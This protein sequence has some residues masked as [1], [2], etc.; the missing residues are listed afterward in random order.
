MHFSSEK[1]CDQIP[2]IVLPSWDSS[3]QHHTNL[4][5]SP[6]GSIDEHNDLK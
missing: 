6:L 1:P 5:E 2:E 4:I 3:Q